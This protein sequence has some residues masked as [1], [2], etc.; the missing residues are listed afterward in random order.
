M[1]N[2]L[3]MFVAAGLLAFLAVSMSACGGHD[4]NLIWFG[5]KAPDA[6]T[7]ILATFNSPATISWNPVSGATSYNIYY[8]TDPD[9]TKAT[10][11]KI[12]SATSPHIIPDGTLAD[13]T[14]YYF[15][16]TAVNSAGRESVPS[17]K[18]SALH[19][20][21]AQTDLEGPWNVTL[22]WTGIGNPA[23]YLGW[24]RMN[25]TLDAAGNATINY[26]EQSDGN[27]SI[28][29]GALSFTI[30]ADGIVTQGG[31]FG[32]LASHNVM[33][34]NKQLIVG[35]NTFND[36]VKEIRIF[37][38]AD[39][40]PVF[41]DA[42]LIN[43]SFAFHQ[44]GS[45][46]EVGWVR[47]EG[48][49]NASREVTITSI[50]DSAGGGTIPPVD[51]LSIDA[52]GVVLSANDPFFRGFMSLDKTLVV[53][54]TRDAA[55]ISFQ[56]RI[57]QTTGATFTMGDL[58]G[59]YAFSS[60]FDGASA[61]WQY[62]TVTINSSGLTTF[63]SYLDSNAVSVLPADLTISMNAA[64]TITN[65]ADATYHGTMSF[66]KDLIVSTFTAGSVGSELYAL[67]FTLK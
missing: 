53:G 56:L 43:K 13:N 48:S 4:D 26:Y 34:S 32:G 8:S 6:P 39:T 47:G 57:I 23:T 16:V 38:R 33:S 59:A 5:G 28:P 50:L 21:F 22:F 67:S 37:Q 51:T 42:D 30:D 64:G 18:V 17:L 29:M 1:R 36:T 65:A 7:G 27:T 41:S 63:L 15:F 49:I 24:L 19:A 46:A 44:L 52:N 9:F 14:T 66:N 58:A 54:T 3:R 2:V 60:L 55:G 12:S 45:G 35:T 20:T 31:D 10:G 61:L 40:A 25:I 62:G 11:T